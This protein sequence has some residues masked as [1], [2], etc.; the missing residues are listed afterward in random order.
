MEKGIDYPSEEDDS[1]N[2]D[3]DLEAHIIQT[4]IQNY[5]IEKRHN[6]DAKKNE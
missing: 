6:E 2:V 1:C 3:D 4:N 5:R